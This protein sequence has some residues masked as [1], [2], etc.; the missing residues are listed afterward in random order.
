ML[1]IVRVSDGGWDDGPGRDG[2]GCVVVV[3]AFFDVVAVVD[4]DDV[5]D[6]ESLVFGSDLGFTV[7]PV[8]G[9]AVLVVVDD[10][11][12]ALLVVGPTGAAASVKVS[13][14]APGRGSVLAGGAE[15]EDDVG[16]AEGL[17]GPASTAGA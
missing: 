1:E 7:E 13:A 14:V 4:D 9:P 12:G 10:S 17:A 2:G 3:V 15:A 8:T 11:G 16:P 5:E 6:D